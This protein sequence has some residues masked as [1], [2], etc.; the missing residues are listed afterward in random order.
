MFFNNTFFY[1][2]IFSVKI[3]Y[4]TT[5]NL[6]FFNFRILLNVILINFLVIF[7]C[8]LQRILSK[9]IVNN[10]KIH[11][12]FL[13][14]IF[15]RVILSCLYNHNNQNIPLDPFHTRGVYYSRQHTLARILNLILTCYYSLLLLRPIKRL[16][17]ISP[18]RYFWH[19]WIA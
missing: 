17:I 16:F 6:F 12:A 11:Q 10:I 5:N 15:S 3:S 18:S 2:N 9:L 4:Y 8:T 19:L 14:K 1:P 13:L 7:I